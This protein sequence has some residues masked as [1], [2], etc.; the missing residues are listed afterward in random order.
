MIKHISWLHWPDTGTNRCVRTSST[1]LLKPIGLRVTIQ[2]RD[3]IAFLWRKSLIS[4]FSN[5]IHKWELVDNEHPFLLLLPTNQNKAFW[6]AYL[7]WRNAWR[8]EQL[9]YLSFMLQASGRG[10]RRKQSAQATNGNSD[11]WNKVYKRNI[12]KRDLRQFLIWRRIFSSQ[13]IARKHRAFE[14]NHLS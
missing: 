14:D 6:G 8:D 4:R 1:N 13:R 5:H 3:E 12:K 10:E 7:A 11:P 9:P 2:M